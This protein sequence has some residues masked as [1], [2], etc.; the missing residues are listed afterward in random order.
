MGGSAANMDSVLN[1]LVNSGPKSRHHKTA[2]YRLK[3]N[4]RAT[5]PQIFANPITLIYNILSNIIHIKKY[6]QKCI[7][8]KLTAYYNKNKS[9]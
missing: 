6:S 2:E 8:C 9:Q 3:C 5:S 4:I 7:V 1:R